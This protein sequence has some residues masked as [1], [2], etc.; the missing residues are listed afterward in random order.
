MA[1]RICGLG[2]TARGRSRAA[3]DRAAIGK[4]RVSDEVRA[5]LG[6]NTELG[7]K[8]AAQLP[9]GSKLIVYPGVGHVRHFEVIEKFPQDLLEFI[10]K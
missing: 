4:N 8:V 5:T 10:G 7:K 3:K 9:A 2:A 6:Q 1:G